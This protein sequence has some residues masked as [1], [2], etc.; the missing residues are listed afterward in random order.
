MTQDLRIWRE[1]LIVTALLAGAT[2]VAVH[3][4]WFWRS[5]HAVYDAV[6]PVWHRPPPADIVIVA[7][8]DESLARIGR[9][10]WRRAVHATLV[11]RLNADGAK[12]IG[13]DIMFTEPDASDAASD[14]ALVEAMHRSGKVV[15][16][17]TSVTIDRARTAQQLPLPDFAGAAAALGSAHVEFDADALARR[18]K[19]WTAGTNGAYPHFAM[20]V[21]GVSGGWPGSGAKPPHGPTARAAGG[22]GE[23]LL[24]PYAGPPGHFHSVSYADVLA[25]EVPAGH[26]RD[27]IV[28]VGATGAGLGDTYATPTSRHNRI[29]TGVEI[30]ANAIDALRRSIFIEPIPRLA[31]GLLAGLTVVVLLLALRHAT[32]R[33]GLLLTGAACV[34]TLALSVLLLRYGLIW[35]TPMAALFGC[36]TAYPVWSWRRLEATQRFLDVELERLE[37]EPPLLGSATPV[38]LRG[39]DR[40]HRRIETLRMATDAR[41]Q[42]RRFIS[43]ALESLPVGVLVTDAAR[44]V[45]LANRNAHQLLGLEQGSALGQP[46]AEL[47]RTLQI[48]PN[49]GFETLLATHGRGAAPTQAETANDAGTV[50]LLGVAASYLEDEDPSAYIVSLVNV[51]ELRSAQLVRDETMRFISHDL[52]APLASIIS[53]VDVMRDPDPEAA[54]LFN[55]DQVQRLARRAL[56]LAEDF[57]R[58]A[59]AE[60]LDAKKLRPVNLAVMA[61]QAVNEITPLARSRRVAVEAALEPAPGSAFS[62]GDADL[63]RRAVINLLNNAVRYS[64]Q[65]SKVTMGLRGDAGHWILSVADEG[66]GI[67]P[68]QMPQLFSRYARLSTGRDEEGVGLGLVIVK[69]VVTRHGG[70][71]SVDSV[72]GRGTR[73]IVNLPGLAQAAPAPTTVE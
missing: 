5:D 28:L 68:D 61:Q 60:A 4:E 50:L 70:S 52:R 27:K 3:Y 41:R 42:S 62:S 73:F 63:L 2:I 25:G 19:L 17:I 48:S 43:E 72:P 57:M 65:G 16:P 53:M 49:N 9:W 20:A 26:F 38:A 13:I 58:L 35:Y 21:L 10:P 34:G 71:V 32:P 1:W 8:D 11:D 59:R 37:Q 69:T 40:L 44:N 23:P 55:L 7:I 15:L 31:A 54:G 64:S 6:L 66:P 36:L 33:N 22:S 30:H 67:P 39:G 45:V 29:M 47:L 51:S 24:L 14:A 12:G 18:V 46:L 56:D